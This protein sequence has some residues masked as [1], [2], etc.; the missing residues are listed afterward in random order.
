MHEAAR[1][2]NWRLVTAVLFACKRIALFVVTYLN[3][4]HF[5]DKIRVLIALLKGLGTERLRR[6]M[7]IAK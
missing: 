2:D 1:P 7:Q 5:A 3:F 4:E 6:R